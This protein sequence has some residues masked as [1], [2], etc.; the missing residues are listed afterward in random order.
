[1]LIYH[2]NSIITNQRRASLQNFIEN[3]DPDCIF[4]SETKLSKNHKPYFENY[5]MYRDDRATMAG[6]T[7]ILIKESIKATKKTTV[8]LSGFKCLETTII[9]INLPNNDKLYLISAYGVGNNRR[10]FM[11]ELQTLFTELKLHEPDTFYLMAGDLTTD[12]K[13]G[14]TPA[15]TIED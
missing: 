10:E 14:E 8:S 15:P 2:V 7:A 1:M 12:T 4:L 3:N 9:Q 5:R 13:T 6:G 11:T